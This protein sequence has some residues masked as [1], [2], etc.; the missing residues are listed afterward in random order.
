[1]LHTHSDTHTKLLL[2]YNI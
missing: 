2:Q 1:M